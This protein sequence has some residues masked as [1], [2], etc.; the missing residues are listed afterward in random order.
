METMEMLKTN[1]SPWMV[2][3]G[4]AAVAATGALLWSRRMRVTLTDDNALSLQKTTELARVR[5]RSGLTGLVALI[6]GGVVY[7]QWKNSRGDSA[8]GEV[9]DT[10]EVAVPLSTAYNQWTQFEEFPRFMET[11]EQVRQLDDQHL[12]WRANVAGKTKEWDAEI[13]E[14]VPDQRIAWRSTSGVKNS[15]V[16]TFQKVGD[17]RTRVKLRMNY[18]PE[19][20]E[21]KV[22]SALGGVKLTTVANLRRFKELVESRGAETGAWR[23][24]IAQH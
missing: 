10:I 11:V 6:L 7:S 4:V 24:S 14:Q 23:G 19:S 8:G 2:A 16:V 22:G 12:H 3:A 15:G 21:E 5:P 13:T 1:K 17:N 9:E 18:E 20:A